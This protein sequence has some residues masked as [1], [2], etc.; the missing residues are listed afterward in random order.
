MPLLVS[1]ALLSQLLNCL[2]LFSDPLQCCKLQ[3]ANKNP[4]N[5]NETGV[6]EGV[7]VSGQLD[8]GSCSSQEWD[9]VNLQNYRDGRAPSCLLLGLSKQ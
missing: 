4:G 1:S 9:E 6:T 2:F 5:L 7:V 8:A 3:T